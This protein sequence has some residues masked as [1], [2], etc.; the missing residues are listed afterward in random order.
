M[1]C[2]GQLRG[3]VELWG[4]DLQF[5]RFE[6]S[7]TDLTAVAATQPAGLDVVQVMPPPSTEALH[8][9]DGAGAKIAPDVNLRA[10]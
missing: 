5:V 4:L 3:K 6:S 8:F 1:P 9:V 7:G 10:G 2:S